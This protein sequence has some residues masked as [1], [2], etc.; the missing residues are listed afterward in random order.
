MIFQPIT[1]RQ[2][3]DFTVE[4]TEN[5]LK[6]NDIE[7]YVRFSEDATDLKARYTGSG[8]EVLHETGTISKVD[9][10]YTINLPNA[11]TKAATIDVYNLEL[12]YKIG[13]K[14]YKPVVKE[15]IKIIENDFNYG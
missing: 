3:E 10:K 2:G 12:L 9:D 7:M 14:I 15:L 8:G 13:E 4:L 11:K 1:I 5:T 6:Y